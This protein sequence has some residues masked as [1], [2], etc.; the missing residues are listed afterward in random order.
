MRVDA[1]FV[2][3]AAYRVIDRTSPNAANSGV[4]CPSEP[5]IGAVSRC[6]IDCRANNGAHEVLL[7]SDL[8]W[9]TD[10]RDCLPG[11]L[12]TDEPTEQANA[13]RRAIR[14]GDSSLN[15]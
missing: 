3:R 4:V 2:P 14:H 15:E 9:F 8:N 12:L 5:D 10:L 1:S 11:R 7:H 13:M 6:W